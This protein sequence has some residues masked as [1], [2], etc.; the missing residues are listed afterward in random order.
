M[1]RGS[2]PAPGIRARFWNAG[3]LLGSASIEVE[4]ARDGGKPLRLLF[5]GDIGPDNKMLEQDPEAPAGF[6]FVICESTYGGRDRFE[7]SEAARRALLAAEVNAA[8]KRKG[9]LLI[10]SFA[11]ERTQE[12]VTDLVTLME[13]GAVPQAPT[14]SSTRRSPARPP[15]IFTK[16]ARELQNGDDAGA[17]L[18]LRHCAGRP[19]A[20]KIPRRWRASP[21]SA[22]SSRPAACARPAASA[23][24]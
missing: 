12:I 18:Q 15:R 9:A 1:K 2:T 14:S 11:V 8:A 4:V 23:I 19:R 16:H 13:Q 21:A 10:P 24:T 17:R 5:S 20:S 22:S 3:H 6:D 7:R